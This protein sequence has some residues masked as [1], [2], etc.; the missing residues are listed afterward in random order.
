M[1]DFALN[2]FVLYFV[3]EDFSFMTSTF[4]KFCCLGAERFDETSNTL[5]S[6]VQT[7]LI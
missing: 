7:F 6:D 3:N 5:Q 4:L 2:I 1:E